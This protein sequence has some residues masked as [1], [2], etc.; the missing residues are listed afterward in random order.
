MQETQKQINTIELALREI[1]YGKE[2]NFID[3]KLEF[4]KKH[5]RV[6]DGYRR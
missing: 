1:D 2:E 6:S 3:N 5:S 4:F